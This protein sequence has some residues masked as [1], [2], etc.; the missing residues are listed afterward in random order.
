MKSGVEDILGLL[1]GHDF[2]LLFAYLLVPF[3]FLLFLYHC[4]AIF[5]LHCTT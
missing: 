4:I 2:V 5:A 1:I 3:N